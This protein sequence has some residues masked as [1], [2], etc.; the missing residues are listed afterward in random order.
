MKDSKTTKSSAK[1]KTYNNK[2]ASSHRDNVRV[3]KVSPVEENFLDDEKEDKR[4]IV[5]IAIAILVIIGTIIGLLVGC[6]KEEEPEPEKPKNEDIVTPIDNKQ[7]EEEEEEGVKTKE[8]VR[9]VAAI[10][11]SDSEDDNE[12]EE[13]VIIEDQEEEKTTHTV[14]YVIYTEGSGDE[15]TTNE[16]EVEDGE[17]AEDSI[18]GYTDCEFFEENSEE[19]DFTKPITEDTT[20]YAYC[21]LVHYT[22]EYVNES[23]AENPN[24]ITEYTVEDGEIPLE[25]IDVSP[26]HGWFATYNSE[27]E[28]YSDQVN[29]LKE[30]IAFA[31]DSN[32]VVIYASFGLKEGNEIETCAYTVVFL[33]QDEQVIDVVCKYEDEGNTYELPTSLDYCGDNAC[34]GFVDVDNP[35][36][37]V[38][39]PGTTISI[40]YEIQLKVI[41]D[42]GSD[43]SGDDV[44]YGGCPDGDDNCYV[45][46]SDTGSG[47]TGND[48]QSGDNENQNTCDPAIDDCTES[49]DNSGDD[50]GYGGCPDGDDDC[51]VPGT[52]TGSGDTGNDGQSGDSENQNT[53]NPAVEECTES[54]DNSGDDVGYGGCPDGDDDCYVPGSDTGSGDTGNDGQ[55]GD[56]DNLV[57]N[58]DNE[59][60]NQEQGDNNLGDNTGSDSGSGAQV[61]EPPVNPDDSNPDD[62]NLD[63]NKTTN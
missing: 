27:T 60:G 25:A 24:T 1:K 45:P 31:D 56:N 9:K 23:G 41:C 10:S 3:T 13:E 40:D 44:G 16:K 33:G 30:A 63:N 51:Y 29:S 52:D 50:V 11:N 17:T 59:S 46:G 20:I 32:N 15:S 39:E 21:S 54:T 5:F 48:D 34:L 19:F 6:Q 38:I 58:N 12:K 43:D 61:V 7:E 47:D 18:L 8:V 42:A 62:S 4:L 49:T 14:T 37:P 28:E 26:W 35:N 2:N 57:N 53:C 22:I 55:S 36:S